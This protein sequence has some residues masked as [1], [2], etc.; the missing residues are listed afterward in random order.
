[1]HWEEFLP[2]DQNT[3]ERRRK[4]LTLLINSF[5]FFWNFGPRYQLVD[6]PHTLHVSWRYHGS[7]D[8]F[9]SLQGCLFVLAQPPQLINFF[10]I[11]A[12]VYMSYICFTLFSSNFFWSNP[13]GPSKVSL[14][15]ENN[16]S[17]TCFLS[18]GA[19]ISDITAFWFR[20]QYVS[21][22]PFRGCIAWEYCKING[23]LSNRPRRLGSNATCWAFDT[24]SFEAGWNRIIFR[25]TDC[26]FFLFIIDIC[27]I[28]VNVISAIGIVFCKIW[29]LLIATMM[30]PGK[31][32]LMRLLPVGVEPSSGP[33]LLSAVIVLPRPCD[34][35][36]GGVKNRFTNSPGGDIIGPNKAPMPRREPRGTKIATSYST[37]FSSSF[38]RSLCMSRC[39]MAWVITVMPF[40]C[41]FG[42][43]I[44]VLRV[45]LSIL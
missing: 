8:L 2:T 26:T 40:V 7:D 6:I 31:T 37:H 23:E 10:S 21:S 34:M 3:H 42:S 36:C 20:S 14:C 12:I 15:F 18:N 41:L 22:S 27:E 43:T 4:I 32:F 33:T 29:L 1:M 24:N 30:S 44:N 16:S 39:L 19:K 45:S 13:C 9:S 35:F 11:E 17:K 5:S 38:W 25:W 28:M